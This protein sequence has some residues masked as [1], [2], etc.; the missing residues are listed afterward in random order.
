MILD[1][2]T[3]GIDEDTKK[4]S[5]LEDA[6]IHATIQA[7]AKFSEYSTYAFKTCRQTPVMV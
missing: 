1:A 3:E 7:L 4:Y 2:H 5:L 6:V